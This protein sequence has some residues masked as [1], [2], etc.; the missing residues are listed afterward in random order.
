VRLRT[1]EVD[2][3]ILRLAELLERY[4]VTLTQPGPGADIEVHEADDGSLSFELIGALPGDTEPPTA[5]VE[6]REELEPDSGGYRRA[7]YEYE[8]ID[9][10]RDF[11]RAFHLHDPDW[12]EREYMVVVHE[13]CERPIAN[14]TCRHYQGTPI[15]DGYEGVNVLLA[16]WIAEPPD[17]ASLDCLD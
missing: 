4:G 7:R 9:H 17:C 14:S 16:S 10:G 8:L 12:F 2:D 1:S 5:T 13:H 3:Y 6:L 15:R 11:R